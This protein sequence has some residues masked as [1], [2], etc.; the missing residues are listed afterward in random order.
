MHSLLLFPFS[1]RCLYSLD[2]VV[3]ILITMF[4]CTGCCYFHSHTCNYVRI[5][6]MLL[7]YSHNDVHMHRMLLFLP[8][9]DGRIHG[10]FLLLFSLGCSYAP[11]VAVIILIMIVIYT[12]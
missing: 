12:G 10:M 8:H 7:F 4:I 6:W 9:N 1:Q 3:F 11:D 5:H 2:A